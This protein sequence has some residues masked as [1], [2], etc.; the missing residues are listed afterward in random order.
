MAVI[1]KFFK[2]LKLMIEAPYNIFSRKI[3]HP[4]KPELVV[5]EITEACNSRCKHCSIWK[6]VPRKDILSADEIE[7]ALRDPVFKNLKAI[8]IT[9]GEA[10]LRNDLEEIIVRINKIFPGRSIWLSTNAIANERA[11]KLIKS[12]KEKG[13]NLGVGVSLDAADSNHDLSRGIPGNFKRADILLKELVKLR[14][15]YPEL[16]ITIGYTLSSFTV[17]NYRKLKAYAKKLNVPL[18]T[19]IYNQGDYYDNDTATEIV[20]DDSLKEVVNDLQPSL[21]KQKALD[22]LDKKSIR[23]SCY[24]LHKFF[25]LKCNGDIAPCLNWSN[26]VIGNVRKESPTEV[27]NSLKAREVRGKIKKCNGCLNDWCTNESFKA[28][29]FPLIPDL[30]RGL[31]KKHT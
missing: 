15:R 2:G 30:I 11:F 18:L 22:Y 12:V 19:Q 21:F 7:K 23:F 25:V 31:K 24:A 16:P 29:F 26:S 13:I 9:G 1:K 6:R 8:L 4:L 20:V 27:W 5:F 10:I 14:K 28:E 3:S 17:K